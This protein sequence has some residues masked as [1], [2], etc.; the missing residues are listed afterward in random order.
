MA[1]N[2]MI[3]VS[4]ELWTAISKWRSRLHLAKI[5]QD[6]LEAEVHKL[7]N[8]PKEIKQMEET[9]ERLR[10]EAKSFKDES[11]SEG[12]A[13][14]TEWAK[15]AKY[16]ELRQFASMRELLGE[17]LLPGFNILPEEEWE[18][19]KSFED[20]DEMSWD[21]DEYQLGWLAAVVKFWDTVAD[22]I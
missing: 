15:E 6:A 5:C 13:R 3:T 9:I 10:K 1:H 18:A 2:L 22:K 14:G 16:A 17:R 20:E 11:Y 12:Y 8:V 21:D 7:E 4:D 19:K